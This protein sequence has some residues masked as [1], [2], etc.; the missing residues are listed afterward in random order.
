VAQREAFGG[1]LGKLGLAAPLLRIA[2]ADP[3]ALGRIGIELVRVFAPHRDLAGAQRRLDVIGREYLG[4]GR[5]VERDH[6]PGRMRH[7]LQEQASN[8]PGRR[9]HFP[10]PRH[11][12]PL[13]FCPRCE[14]TLHFQ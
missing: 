8:Q 12:H 7:A 14:R 9:R 10:D 1:N 4:A 6:R 3:N 13:E 11:S 5:F 2:K